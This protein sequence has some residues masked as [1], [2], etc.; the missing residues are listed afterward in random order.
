[1]YDYSKLIGR[2]VTVF[3]TRF[4]FAFELGMTPQTLT[5][6]LR[7]RQ[8]WNQE[9]IEKAC[10]LLGIPRSEI[11]DYFFNLNVSQEERKC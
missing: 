7:N 2:I 3:G 6:K 9:Q 10:E 11:T 5:N 8:P 4:D 1:M